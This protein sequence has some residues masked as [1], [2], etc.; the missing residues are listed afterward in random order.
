MAKKNTEFSIVVEAN[1]TQK[2]YYKDL[3]RYRE[4]FYLLAWR[5]IVVRYKQTFLGILWALIRPLLNMTVFAFVFG[6]IA[7]LPSGH[8]SYPLFVLAG[9]LPWQLFAGCLVDTSN[10]LLNNA[11]MISKIYFPRLILPVTHIMVHCVDF[12]ISL[13]LL[14]LVFLFSGYLTQWTILLLPFF[15]FLTLCLCLGTSLWLSAAT[16]RYRDVRFIVPFLVQFGVFISP[17]GYSSFLLPETWRWLY[18]C[19]PMAGIIE[20]FRW[21]CFGIYHPE[22]PL[23]IALSC[24][25]NIG[26][27]LT[28][29]RFFRKIER[30]LSDII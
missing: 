10:S 18:F 13:L 15:I 28:G 26:L 27:L 20:G 1:S 25:V 30:V 7:N 21:C 19:N 29:F 14:L 22:L 4:L 23:A 6:K 16:V 3:F 5:D 11:P 8:V 2:E 9:M 24:L 17:V 12:F